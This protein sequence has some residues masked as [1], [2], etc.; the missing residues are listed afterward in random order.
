MKVVL[1]ILIMFIF[2]LASIH[3]CAE[4]LSQLSKEDAIKILIESLKDNNRII[5]L[6]SYC[7]KEGL[8]NTL[9]GENNDL[10]KYKTLEEKGFIILKPLEDNKD[11]EKKYG[12]VFT[13]KAEPY[14]IKKDDGSKDKA[15]VSIGKAEKIDLMQLKPVSPKEYKAE[16]LIGYRL[17]PFGEILMGKQMIFEK[18]EDVFFEHRD[19][20]WKIRFKTSF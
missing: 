9:I 12:I 3:V 17:T 6:K 20:G 16:F 15:L 1:K 14:I 18:K 13:E 4:S 10:E 2:S 8:I 11:R 5:D 7:S 19:G